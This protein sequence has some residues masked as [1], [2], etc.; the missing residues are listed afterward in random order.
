M[1]TANAVVGA[2]LIPVIMIAV[3]ADVIGRYFLD[4]PIGW[5][6]E[7]AEYALLAIPFLAM[8]WLVGYR[9]G[10]VRIDLLLQ[11]IP[12]RWQ[13]VLEAGTSGLAGLTCAAAAWFA[14]LTT[15]SQYQRGVVTI[16]IY[17]VPKYLLISIIVYGLACT[18]G[19]LFRRAWRAWGRRNDNL[20]SSKAPG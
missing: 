10:H 14:T 16:G 7:F 12:P 6:I 20:A 3:S 1:I 13:A 19:E 5:V 4:A 2:V 8:A 18:A 11:A 9:D 17:P 15:V